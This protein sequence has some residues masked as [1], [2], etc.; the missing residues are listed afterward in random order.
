MS[1]PTLSIAAAAVSFA[2]SAHARAE[3]FYVEPESGSMTGDGSQASPWSTLEDVVASGALGSTIQAAA[4]LAALGRR[5]RTPLRGPLDQP[6]VRR[7]LRDGHDRRAPR[8]EPT[9]H[10]RGL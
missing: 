7:E 3:D 1:R 8:G 10:R 5:Q 4:A 6:V 2:L 9:R